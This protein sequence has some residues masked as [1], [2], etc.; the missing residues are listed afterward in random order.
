[1][2]RGSGACHLKSSRDEEKVK[3]IVLPFHS[4]IFDKHIVDLAVIDKKFFTQLRDT[5]QAIADAKVSRSTML[6]MCA[7]SSLEFFWTPI[8]KES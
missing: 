5:Y 1:M 7:D 4:S 2:I 8:F 3:G 6:E